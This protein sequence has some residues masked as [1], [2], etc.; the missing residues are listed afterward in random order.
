MADAPTEP[1]NQ[2]DGC[3][4]GIPIDANGNH[5]MGAPGKYRDLMACQ[6][7][8]YASLAPVERKTEAWRET[9]KA[10]KRAVLK[11]AGDVARLRAALE[12]YGRHEK[13][14]RCGVDFYTINE[15]GKPVGVPRPCTCG[16]DAALRGP[17]GER[18][19][20]G[21]PIQHPEDHPGECCDCFDV[22]CGMPLAQ[23]NEERSAKGVWPLAARHVAK[24]PE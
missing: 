19:P 18:C 20:C 22:G 17:E 9:S 8:K 3:A 12:K 15:G 6:A 1:G 21:E 13:G 4:A 16:L 5:A 23:V 2:C 11:L 24:V 10:H 14:A 7:S